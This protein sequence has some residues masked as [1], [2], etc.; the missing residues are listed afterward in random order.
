MNQA[1]LTSG[2]EHA[3]MVSEKLKE[4]TKQIIFCSNLEDETFRFYQNVAKKMD[5]PELRSQITGIAY[6]S[7][8][9][10]MTIR[11]LIKAVEKPE[12]KPQDRPKAVAQ[13]Q[14]EITEVSKQINEAAYLNTEEF[15]EVFKA[16]TELED[17][18]A[19]IYISTFKP[20]NLQAPTE[21]L[22]HRGAINAKTLT[23]I[24]E[25]ITRD[26]QVHRET[27][28]DISYAYAAKE[29]QAQ[30]NAPVVRYT[31]PDRWSPPQAF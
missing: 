2:G 30:S 27:L 23:K 26:K 14:D 20:K 3:K 5:P 1:Y 7:L 18:L 13:L 6:D 16:S 19:E 22:D 21:E 12:I 10:G 15:L 28:F 29:Q 11:E 24:F 17:R 31:N 25:D 8:K 4:F 9:H